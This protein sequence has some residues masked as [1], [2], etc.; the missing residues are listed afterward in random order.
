MPSHPTS[1]TSDYILSQ[2]HGPMTITHIHTNQYTPT[3][4]QHPI[5]TTQYTPPNIHHPIYTTQARRTTVTRTHDH[6]SLM[7]VRYQIELVGNLS[8]D[9]D[10][11]AITKTPSLLSSLLMEPSYLSAS[12]PTSKRATAKALA[13]SPPRML[14]K[15]RLFSKLCKV[16]IEWPSH[17][18][19]LQRTPPSKRRRR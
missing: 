19:R 11:N 5:Y 9:A 15:L 18:S 12:P 6:T 3:N 16:V 17:A 2:P 14:T 8:F 13:T 1:L 4:I 10:E 7:S